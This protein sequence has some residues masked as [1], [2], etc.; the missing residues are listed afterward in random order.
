MPPHRY[1]P[2]HVHRS[3]RQCDVDGG[4]GTHPTST[5]SPHSLSTS[6][7]SLPS[8]ASLPPLL[9]SPTTPTLTLTLTLTFTSNLILT[10]TLSFTQPIESMVGLVKKLSENPNYQLQG[11][12]KSKYETE[13]VRIALAKIVGL[14]QVRRGATPFLSPSPTIQ[15]L[16]LTLAFTLTPHP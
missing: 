3:L 15:I 16:T 14:M 11:E 5:L 1:H 6:T 9:S 7:L 13:A 12:S 2:H 8:T 10:L 4:A